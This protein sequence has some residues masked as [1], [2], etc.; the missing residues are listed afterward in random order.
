MSTT[1]QLLKSYVT[2]RDGQVHYRRKQG[3]QT[4]PVILLHQTASSGV[5]YEAVMRRLRDHYVI[6]FDT[7]GYGESF[8]PPTAPSMS[9]YAGNLAECLES[10]GIDRCDIFG[11]HT[12]A[13]TAAQ[14]AV[15]YP[16]RVNRLIL[17]GMP[18][19]SDEQKA[20][21]AAGLADY[22]PRPDGS[23]LAAVWSRITARTGDDLALA[24]R[25]TMLTL[26]AT[27]YADSYHAVF[28]QDAAACLRALTCPTLLIGGENDS[29]R[30]SLE[31]ADTILRD[32]PQYAGMR[33]LANADTYV[34]DKQPDVIAGVIS[35]FFGTAK[36]P[37][38]PSAK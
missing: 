16:Q 13:A 18:V 10:L 4:R 3:D 20:F 35:E 29:L 22:S 12:G 30:A 5:M 17:S 19:L 15:E 32:N 27:R 28:E 38:T 14:L 23:H 33:L 37:G 36:T 34:C 31:P 24:Q 11:H 1:A 26:R 25:E 9:Y 8:D 6:A 7:P 21:F 2:T